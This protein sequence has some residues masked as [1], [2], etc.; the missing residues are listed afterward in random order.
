VNLAG[1]GGKPQRFHPLP[2]VHIIAASWIRTSEPNQNEPVVRYLVGVGVWVVRH[3]TLAD[4]LPDWYS[5]A[6][7]RDAEDANTL[8]F[9][10]DDDPHITLIPTIRRRA[11]RY[12]A[13]CEVRRECLTQALTL[14]EE[15]GIWGGTTGGQ[16]RRLR[17][18]L[19]MGADLDSVVTNTLVALA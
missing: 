7:C 15:Y 16:R 6:G 10:A 8:F 3:R 17:T 11:R 2:V 9:G 5:R 13:E 19:A 14:P 18:M 1:L 12:C 4:W